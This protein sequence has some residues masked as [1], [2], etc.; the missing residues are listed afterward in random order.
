METIYYAASNPGKIL[1]AQKY[2]GEYNIEM[3]YF[4][5]DEPEINNIEAIAIWKV[6]QAYHKL[7]KPCVALDS[8]FYI[9]NYP[10][11][12][13]FP[14]AFVKRK[15]VEGIGIDGLL[16]KMEG[17]QNRECYFLECV[18]FYDGKTLKTFFG[19]APGVLATKKSN[20]VN[21]SGWSNLNQ[22]FMPDGFDK[23]LSE[24]TD[25]EKKKRPNTTH[26]FLELKNF[27][28]QEESM[29]KVRRKELCE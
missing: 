18:A 16:E 15:L 4:D 10:G 2:L 25:E 28:D 27:F 26:A 12:P 23:P 5:F 7:G 3:A 22:I 17:I 14:G 21:T 13:F 8:G 1:S 19:K 29:Q 24:L 20:V 9:P 11:E 6:K